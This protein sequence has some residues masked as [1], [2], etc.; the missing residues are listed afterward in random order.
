MSRRKSSIKNTIIAILSEMMTTFVGL[1][2]PQAIIINYGSQTNGL[3]TSLQQ[4]I[5]YF[6]LIESGLA[7]AAIFALYKPLAENN[8][9]L[10]D[11]ILYSVKL[12]YR[13]MGAVFVLA[14]ITVS[15]IY[16]A[17]TADT[18]YPYWM[19]SLLFCLIGLNGAT[20]LLFIG[21][22]KVLLN[23]SQ[24]NRYVTLLN[25]ISTCLFSLIIIICSYC[26]LHIL[27]TVALGATAYLLRALGYYIIVRKK[28]PQYSFNNPSEEYHFQNQREVF[29]QQI[30]TM[31]ILNSGTLILLLSKTDMVEISVFSIYNLVLTAVF[32]LTNSAGAGVS[33]SFGDL[34]ARRDK[35]RLQKAYGEYE[36]LYQVFW[37]ITFACVTVLY[38]PF[39]AIYTQSFDDVQ[40]I[41]PSLCILFSLY[42][43]VWS[44][45]M[46]QSIFIVAAGKFKEIQRSSLFEAV[47]TVGLS[48]I[49]MF[50]G[51]IEGLMIGRIMTATYRM[52]DFTQFN[53][54]HIIELNSR[55]TWKGIICSIMVI[56]GV[57]LLSNF[58]QQFFMIDTYI[59]WFF[60]AICVALL[61]GVISVLANSIL[62]REEVKTLSRKIKSNI[63]ES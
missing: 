31:I 26:R 8:T 44:I 63:A 39:I 37:T 10:I 38:M 27:C 45:R 15:L 30:L 2:F 5:Q 25:T 20:Q 62:Y 11:R 23:A 22:Y 43:A 21:K 4:V 7:G 24:N 3:I 36:V 40:Y 13:K 17:V 50:L 35:K 6:T 53:H 52:I 32:L 19:V 33:A 51:G 42:G 41:R 59:E 28:F 1:L 61:S 60:M 55:F 29:V 34:I 16:P 57:N 56:V 58:A 12:I 18:E 54:K 47:A 48:V 49:G 46:Q 9:A 14:I